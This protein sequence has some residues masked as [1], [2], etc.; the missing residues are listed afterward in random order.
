MPS[1]ALTVSSLITS[2]KYFNLF[3]KTSVDWTIESEESKLNSLTWKSPTWMNYTKDSPK[4][5]SQLK[6]KKGLPSSYQLISQRLNS[7]LR[8]NLEKSEKITLKEMKLCSPWLSSA[9]AIYKI[10]R[11]DRLSTEDQTL[12]WAFLFQESSMNLWWEE[13]NW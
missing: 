10:F 13:L 8:T 4:W 6:N 3:L 2:R 1:L 9:K 12:T 5:I 7:S 11:I